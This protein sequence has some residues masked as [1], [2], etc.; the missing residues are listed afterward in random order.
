MR[1]AFI[2][3]HPLLHTLAAFI[4]GVGLGLT[5]S[6]L[7]SPAT[8]V[9][10]SPAILRADF[11]NQYRLVI[12]AAY[13][14]S[15]D[16]ERARARLALLEDPDP[17]QALSAQAQ[18]MLASGEAPQQVELVARLASD[19]EAGIASAPST[20]TVALPVT[21]SAAVIVQPVS[22]TTTATIEETPAPT[23]LV[24]TPLVIA[25]P[26]LRPTHTPTAPPGRAFAL[27][28]QET[29]CDTKISEGLLQVILLDSR[30]RQVAGIEI[31]VTWNGGED[32]FYTG[33]KPEIG[34]GYA[35]FQMEADIVYSVQVVE[36][37][38]PVPNISIPACTDVD[39]RQYRGSVL[40]TFQQ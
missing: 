40:L 12:A 24:E 23:V 19:L 37:G 2:R 16:L 21:E 28:G 39:G 32:R 1:F 7:I 34:N 10:A 17:M 11:K 33:F 15:R 6:W 5:Y 35:D 25:S 30:H 31:I 18:Q 3:S 9:D 27:A 13:G 14:S 8:Y 38:A 29:V 36:S 4:I 22:A 20:A 26:T